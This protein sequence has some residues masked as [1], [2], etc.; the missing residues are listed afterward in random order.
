M[1]SADN[2]AGIFEVH[3]NQSPNGASCTVLRTSESGRWYPVRL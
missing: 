1:R 3:D 2:P